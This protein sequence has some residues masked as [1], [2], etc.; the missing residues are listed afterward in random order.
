MIKVGVNIGLWVL[1]FG[2]MHS[3]TAAA[4]FKAWIQKMVGEKIYQGWYRAFYNL[5][6]LVAIAPLFYFLTGDSIVLWHTTGITALLFSLVRIIGLIGG[7]YAIA[8]I[9]W[10]AFIGI[11]QI[12]VYFRN[13]SYSE[14][15]EELVTTG[16]Y[17]VS[18][19][20]LYFFSLLY[21]WFA[22]SMSASWF[23]FSL[24]AT[25]YFLV[26]SYLE[27]RKMLG[28]FGEQYKTYQ[29]DVA[30]LIPF[31]KLP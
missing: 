1:A 29:Q 26:G 30:W 10:L 21:I 19:H 16:L 6:S 28:L 9:D 4:F 27:E 24:G 25:I 15:K 14:K 18:R 7:L 8:Q 5:L 22:P 2:L 20:P 23:F 3:L 13:V 11:R 17:K 12:R 31:L